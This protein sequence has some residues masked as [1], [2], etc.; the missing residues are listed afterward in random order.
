[1]QKAYTVMT[2]LLIISAL[3][4]LVWVLAYLQRTRI[5]KLLF[6]KTKLSPLI[7]AIEPTD[8]D[9]MGKTK[10]QLSHVATNEDSLGQIE[11]PIE[12]AP[13]FATSN[14]IL[15]SAR[16]DNSELDGAFSDSPEPMDLDIE[17]EYNEAESQEEEYLSCFVEDE[18]IKPA[19]GIEYDE[20]EN[21]IQVIQ[22]SG[23]SPEAELNAVNTI[24]QMNQTELFQLMVSQIEGGKERVTEMLNKYSSDSFE[25]KTMIPESG[26]VDFKNFEINN[27]L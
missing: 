22:Q 7:P 27:F 25:T 10:T 13:T 12:I 4:Y 16:I 6:P 1:M 24:Q 26:N 15:K 8:D 3:L 19:T 23:S 2:N 17:C 11:K 18:N 21:L 14:E 9:V 20:M 5:R